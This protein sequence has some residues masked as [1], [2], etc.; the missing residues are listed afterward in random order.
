[1]T[2][3]V[4]APLAVIGSQS[5]TTCTAATFSYT[6]TGT[7][8]GGTTYGWAVPTLGAG[9][10][11]GVSGTGQTSISD[12]LTNTTVTFVTATYSVTPSLSGCTGSAF[13]LTVKVYPEASIASQTSTACSTVPFSYTPTGSI[14]NGTTYAWAAPILGT[15]LTGGVS[16]TGQSTINDNLNNTT[17]A[18][19]TA[20]YTVTPTS[21]SCTG[22]VFT[23]TVTVNPSATIA[24]QTTTVCSGVA[25]SYTAT[26]TIIPPGT[27]Y[28]WAVPTVGA[29]ITGGASGTGQTTINDNLTN[30]AA[31]PVTATY[32]V[33][34]TSGSCTGS[35]FTVTATVIPPLAVINS[36]GTSTCTAI[37]FSYT[38]TGTIALGTTYAWAAPALGTNLTGGVSGTGQTVISDILTNTTVTFVTATYSVTPSLSGCTGSAFTLTVRVNP[39]PATPATIFGRATECLGALDSFGVL[40]VTGATSYTWSLPNGWTTIGSTIN[41]ITGLAGSS[42]TVSVTANNACGASVPQTF[43]V[44]VD[45]VPPTPGAITGATSVCPGGLDT[46]S[47]APVWEATSYVWTLPNGWTGTSA[48][49]TII[50]T[51]AATAGTVTVMAS[52]ACG[53]SPAQTF[54][55]TIG[56]PPPTP[57]TIS[58]F[59]FPCS[60]TLDTLYIAPVNG[61]TSYT[62]TL[63][64]GWTGTSTTDTLITTAGSAGGNVTVKANNACG[65]SSASVSVLGANTVPP[66]PGVVFSRTS[67][68]TAGSPDT[69]SV[70]PVSGATSYTWTLPSGW[71]GT[72]TSDSIISSIGTNAGTL[73]VVANNV[74]GSSTAQTLAVGPGSAPATPV[75][76]LGAPIACGAGS[77]D[78]LSVAPVSG[79]TS[80]TWTLPFGWTGSSTTNTIVATATSNGGIVTVQAVN[81]CGSSPLQTRA[82]TIGSAPVS[83]GSITS[84]ASGCNTGAMDTFSVAAVSGATSY[85]WTLPGGWIGTSTT[86]TIIA[87]VGASGTVSVTA[88]NSC[89][90]TTPSTLAVTSV[91]ALPTPGA[92]SGQ[93]VVCSGGIDTFSIAPVSGAASYIWTLPN[94]WTGTSSTTSIITTTNATAGYVIVEA[95]N[96]C[97]GSLPQTLPVSTTSIIPPTPGLIGGPSSVCAGATDSFYIVPLNSASLYTWTLPSG[98]I[99]TST[100]NSIIATA[101][102]AGGLITVTAQNGCGT[103]TAQI[104]TDT[105]NPLPTVV[106]DYG[107]PVCQGWGDIVT[108]NM[109]T[110]AGGDYSGPGVTGN[111]FFSTDALSAGNYVLTYTY[112]SPAGCTAS[113]TA[114]FNVI[115]CAGIINTGADQIGVYPNP[116]T[117]EITIN[118]NGS[119]GN[120][121]AIL[122]DAAGREVKRIEFNA[123]VMSVQI[124]T[125]S[126]TGGMYLL[127]ISVGGKLIEVK[128]LVRTE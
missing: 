88:N 60:G 21:G 68:C 10:T 13:A 124:N 111:T 19:V 8:A 117:D 90:S 52:N 89:G 33:T 71:T 36:Q 72:S 120:G 75:T 35:I 39:V 23:V 128:K 83:V 101:G 112:T 70:A 107:N 86:N 16:G 108:L 15:G 118:T 82:I 109:A 31:A 41:A 62:W 100:T 76:I 46:L 78:T 14:P 81:N 38:P 66:I 98:W 22:A 85:T 40:P 55:V 3:T 4:R 126:L 95:R 61:A 105:V 11:G 122:S 106:F 50:A 51:A 49:D 119:Y 2:V 94:G 110:P 79:A 48:T 96:G 77:T 87:I 42:G 47:I 103:S 25:F 116:F 65:S 102:S 56:T 34:P 30:T 63:P 32:S 24:A 97:A 84:S 123:G 53:N 1:M 74:C 114:N 113:D 7:I 80:Y 45:S 67:G 125:S 91:P 58:G 28:A 18:A 93:S 43:A 5:T 37:A 104:K 27:T 64:N 121:T 99:G 115:T 44:T 26:G 6:P 69:F 12:N 127:S 9:L 57:G 73:S 59:T 17:T 92:I 54:A 20:T 29:G